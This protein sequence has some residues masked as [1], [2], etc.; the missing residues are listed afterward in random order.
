M[1]AELRNDFELIHVY[2]LC[3]PTL[4]R[5]PILICMGSCEEVAVCVCP[6]A[7]LQ[8][9]LVKNRSGCSAQ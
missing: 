1:S 8:R 7:P 9:P 6:P 3:Q 5:L 2:H 4:M